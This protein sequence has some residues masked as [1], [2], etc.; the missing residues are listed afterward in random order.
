MISIASERLQAAGVKGSFGTSATPSVRCMLKAE[1]YNI[2]GSNLA[3]G[4]V[5]VAKDENV[6][7]VLA[8]GDSH[9]DVDNMPSNMKWCL[10]LIERHLAKA[11]SAAAGR[12]NAKYTP[13]ANFITTKWGQSSPYNLLTPS[14][15]GNH[16]PVG[17][18]A[19]A[20]AQCMNVFKYPASASFA[21]VYSIKDAKKTTTVNSTYSWDYSDSYGNASLLKGKRIA[22]LMADCGYASGM[23]YDLSGSGTMLFMAGSALVNC[24]N[25]PEESIKCLSRYTC[26]DEDWY[27][28]IYNE[29]QNGSPVLYGG[30]DPTQGGHAFVFSGIDSDGLVYVNWGWNGDGDGFYSIDLLDP[31]PS[32]FS[33]SQDM[34]YGLRVQP[35]PTDY[36]QG[37]ITLINDTTCYSFRYEPYVDEE[38]GYNVQKCIQID[39]PTG[40]GNLNSSTFI[41]DFG[42][43]AIDQTDGSEWI[44]AE[45]DRDTLESGYG[46]YGEG[47]VYFYDVADLKVG[48]TYRMS[49]GARDDRDIRWRSLLCVGGE[50]AYD[51]VIGTDGKATITGPVEVPIVTGKPTAIRST[52]A[53]ANPDGLTRVY[54]LTG[55][56]VY[57]APSQSFNLWDVPARGILV[58]SDANGSRRVVR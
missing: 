9:L 11:G 38:H 6:R 5:I 1:D 32:S 20:M 41:G 21:A 57:V 4:F 19:T 17:C 16:C 26:N 12:R 25:Y 18:V 24:F 15:D 33:E 10:G 54:D 40:M 8:Y 39:I 3:D 2:Y 52:Y 58:V 53:S 42:L 48:H 50:I 43:F 31:S 22:Q 51:V 49:F 30:D 45:T 35:L 27:S 56:Q 23:N 28:I 47:I 14:V 7:P 29:I 44:V 37:L 36:I 34:V 46:T 13:V 55:R